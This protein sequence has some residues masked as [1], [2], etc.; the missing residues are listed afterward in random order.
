ME[1]ICSHVPKCKATGGCEH[2]YN[3]KAKKG[4]HGACYVIRQLCQI[5]GVFCECRTVRYGEYYPP[6]I[7]KKPALETITQP[8]P[9][10]L[11]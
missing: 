5:A 7:I 4:R 3:H 6:I 9:G 11:D 1:Y 2:S 10:I 8:I